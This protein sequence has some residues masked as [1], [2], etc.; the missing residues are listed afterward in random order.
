MFD[1]LGKEAV[2]TRLTKWRA[3][4]NE[5]KLL[6]LPTCATCQQQRYDEIDVSLILFHLQSKVVLIMSKCGTVDVI[7]EY[8]D[9]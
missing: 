1:L 3:A 9:I 7:L 6:V 5:M 4:V 2:I 8:P